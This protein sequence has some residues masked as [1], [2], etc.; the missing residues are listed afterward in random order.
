MPI[1]PVME[2]RRIWFSV[3]G[4]VSASGEGGDDSPWPF[5][6]VGSVVPRESV[7]GRSVRDV[8]KCPV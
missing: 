8:G 1:E 4:V 5:V 7:D 6:T 2:V 3:I